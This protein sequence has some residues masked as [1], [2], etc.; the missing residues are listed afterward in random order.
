MQGTPQ[1][2]SVL[3]SLIPHSVTREVL[4]CFRE[5]VAIVWPKPLNS[6]AQS[7]KQQPAARLPSYL[8]LR[9]SK[10]AKCQETRLV[11]VPPWAI[12]AYPVHN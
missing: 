5:A 1:E 2:H 9:L 7:Q 3:L 11:N 6:G 4:I 10:F 8:V 12:I